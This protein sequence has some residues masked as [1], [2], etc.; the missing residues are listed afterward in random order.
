MH[1]TVRTVAFGAALLTVGAARGYA[2]HTS[3][4]HPGGWIVSGSG[5]LGRTH[6]DAAD[7]DV[8]HVGIRPVGLVFLTSRLA[9]GASL[10][11]SYAHYSN[12]SGHT[13]NYGIGPAARYYFI[14]DTSRWLSFIG[15]AVEPVWQRDHREGLIVV[16]PSGSGSTVTLD[17]HNRVL[18][19]DGS[20]GLTRLLAE[21]VGLTGELYYTHS[22]TS[23]DI[24]PQA[25]LKAYD[26]GARF[27]LTVFVH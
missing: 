20:L 11:L 7:V 19:V 13:A 21:H 15:A 9:L 27:G 10:P 3:P 26:A 5:S 6:S 16:S 4:A 8:T 23:G 24:S 2:Q 12:P 14:A 1:A 22:E 17:S 18:T 25:K